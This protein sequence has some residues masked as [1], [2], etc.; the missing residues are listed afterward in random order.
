MIVMIVR[1]D[2]DGDQKMRTKNQSYY[3][4]KKN[5]YSIIYKL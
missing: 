2:D 4:N 5:C 3:T 1:N